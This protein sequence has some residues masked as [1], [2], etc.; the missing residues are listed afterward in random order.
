MIKS[1]RSGSFI[2]SFLLGGA[3]GGA[4]ALLYAPKSGR[5]LRN[6]I[7]TKTGELIEKGKKLATDSGK[8]AKDLAENTFESAN[9]FLNTGA[10][11]VVNRA[12]RVKDAVQSGFKAY[13][14]EKRSLTDQRN[15]ASNDV[16]NANST[17]K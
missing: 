17:M 3:I 5:N 13:S 16:E 14:D 6:D 7:G 1:N 12:E 9:E 10:A 4:I 2:L 15:L 11:K 8:A